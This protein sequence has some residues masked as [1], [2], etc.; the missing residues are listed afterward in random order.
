[1]ADLPAKAFCDVLLTEAGRRG[2]RVLLNSPAPLEREKRCQEPFPSGF[3]EKVPD[4][5]SL[6]GRGSTAARTGQPPPDQPQ[7]TSRVSSQLCLSTA[8]DNPADRLAERMGDAA[9]PDDWAGRLKTQ[10]ETRIVECNPQGV[11]GS[12][13]RR[14]CWRF[15]ASIPRPG[16]SLPPPGPPLAIFSV[17]G[18]YDVS[19]P[20]RN[21]V[22]S[23]LTAPR[24]HSRKSSAAGAAERPLKSR[25]PECGPG[26]L[27]WRMTLPKAPR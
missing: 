23:D 15:A 3:L 26:L 14:P 10:A 13:G 4:T 27:Q 2:G 19:F 16:G 5:F 9:Y 24:L 22:V 7:G 8:G 21:H 17:A 1:M 25:I 18:G 20:V 12:G 11:S 6:T